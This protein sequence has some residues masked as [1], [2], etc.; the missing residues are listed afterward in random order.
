MRLGGYWIAAAAMLA[1][2]MAF[3][4]D[5]PNACDDLSRA[6]PIDGGPLFLPSYPTAEPGPLR[7]I[8]YLYDNSVAAIALIGCGNAERARR[9]GDAI[10][11]AS[12]HDRAWHDGRLRNAYAAG[13]VHDDPIK[14]GGWWDA[15]Q[16]KWL[17]DEYQ[18][19]SDSG[20]MAWAMLALLALD[21]AFP[22]HRYRDTALRIAGWLAARADSRGAGGYA[23]G[24]LGWEPGP[25]ALEWKSTEHNTDIAAAFTRLAEATGDHAWSDRAARASGFVAAMWDPD[26]GCFAVGTTDDGVTRNRMIAIDA[27]LWPLLAI[28]GQ[29]AEHA[30]QA[31]QAIDTALRA[32]GGYSYS[33]AANGFWTEGTAQAALAATLLGDGEAAAA[34]NAAVQARRAPGG[35][36]YATAAASLATGF[37]D[38][39]DPGVGRRYYHLPHLGATAWAALAEK[40]YNPF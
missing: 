36:Y 35:E 10:V 7:G 21:R 4:A 18:V 34:L 28:P 6:I 3:A 37:A 13:P 24:F 17:E 25:Q 38:P 15:R 31:F 27:E 23:G 16:N 22:D 20:N 19:S 1:P 40:A 29:G 2:V 30:A 33:D 9:I 8:A 5:A 32:D 26:R 39:S 14:L 11:W 12:I